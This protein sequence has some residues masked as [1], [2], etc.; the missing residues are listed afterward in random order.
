M[1]PLSSNIRSISWHKPDKQ[2]VERTEQ[3][4]QKIN[5][6][7]TNERI[8]RQSLAHA[9]TLFSS[10]CGIMILWELHAEISAKCRC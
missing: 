2:N 8:R 4:E 7:E 6:N 3:V 10:V 5:T 9:Q 1:N